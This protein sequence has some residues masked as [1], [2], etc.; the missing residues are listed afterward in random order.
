MRRELSRVCRAGS[1]SSKR[2]KLPV[3]RWR[4]LARSLAN[5]LGAT[6]STRERDEIAATQFTVNR[7]A[8]H[9]QV[10]RALLQIQLG[11]YRP[12]VTGRSGGFGSV[13]LPLFQAGRWTP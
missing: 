11:A 2:T 1:V 5:P 13:I 7:E 6:S 3:F 10:M 12:S 9:C 4:T 8:E